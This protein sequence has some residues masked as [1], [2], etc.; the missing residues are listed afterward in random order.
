MRPLH[1]ILILLALG[2]LAIPASAGADGTALTTIFRTPIDGMTSTSCSTPEPISFSGQYQSVFHY[3]LDGTPVAHFSGA[4]TSSGVGTGLVTGTSYRF[5]GAS[6][7]STNEAP[8]GFPYHNTF[9]N[10]FLLVSHGPGDNLLLRETTHVTINANGTL[11]AEVSNI[12]FD[13]VG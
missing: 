6:S 5:A 4:V 10:T 11:T 3:T 9:T 13:C 2:G 7:S 8:N 1:L 12:S